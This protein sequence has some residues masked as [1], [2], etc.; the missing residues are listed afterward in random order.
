MYDLGKNFEMDYSKAKP[1]SES[2]I[3]GKNFRITILTER[4][5]RFEF[6]KHGNFEDRPTEI[7]WNR[8]FEKP[9]FEKKEDDYFL[10]IETDFFFLSYTKGKNF[11]GGRLNPG[12]N[13]KVTLKGTDKYWYYKH[14]EVRNYGACDTMFESSKGKVLYKKGLYSLDGFVTIDD[15]NSSIMLENG[16][17]E[18]RQKGNI[19][20]YLFVYGKDFASCLKDYYELTGYPALLPRYAL[21]TWWNKNVAYT[22]MTLKQLVDDFS[23]NDIPLSVL[24]LD[25]N[26]H[27]NVQ[28]NKGVLKTGFTFNNMCFKA[29]SEMIKYLHAKGIRLGLTVDPSEGI[30]PIE[31]N[32]EK[33]KSYLE[34][35][36]KGVIPFNIYDP[37]FID[38]Y[39]KLLIHPLDT[40]GVD[41]YFIDY[42]N[43]LDKLNTLKYYQA[44][45]VKRDYQR[46]PMVLSYN[47]SKASHRYP[48]LYSGKT[49]V[50]WDTLKRIPIHN[51]NAANIG[52]SWWSHDIGGYYKGIED[53][54]L[55][56]RYVELGVFSPILKFGSDKCKYYKREPWKWSIKTYT[57]VKEYLDLRRKLIPYL[58][59]E[60]YK[61]HKDG[62][63]L[64]QPLYYKYPEMYDDLLYRNE[65]YFGSEF[66]ISPITNK[67]DYI[68]NRTIH[69][70][71]V[72]DGVWYNFMTGKKFMGG[73][74]HVSFFKEQDYPVFVKAGGIIPLGY[75]DNINDTNPPKNMEIHVFP[76][77]SNM[78]TLNE[79]DGVSTLYEKGYFLRTTIDYNYLPNNYTII[80]RAVEGKSG[81]VPETRNYKII[82]RNTKQAKEIIAYFDKEQIQVSS[83]VDGPNFIVEAKNIKTI[84]QLTI[85]CKG[86]DIEID[87]LR[88]INDDIEGIISDLPIET[89]LKQL[90]DEAIFNDNEVRKKRIAVRRLRSKGLESKFVKLFL[91]LLDYMGQVQ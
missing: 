86:K 66:F 59:S 15:S 8:N 57:I 61:Y 60:A 75:N 72:P 17:T 28:T 5:I 3:V 62:T 56:A 34:A 41:F 11:Y 87:A 18:T 13:L 21:G 54:E 73:K 68:M 35:D 9:K 45:D 37:K 74:K 10:E 4:L 70:F 65:Y 89:D 51:L 82:F 44:Y 7:I 27:N 80:I 12:S 36:S 78:Y 48:V 20:I 16:Q 26:W 81:I 43:D 55:Y 24:L 22:D 42:K 88:I 32:Y 46:R 53:N 50:S 39:L 83:Y 33:I 6:N 64:I 79:D 14:P 47:T 23:D 71:F 58:Y 52:V 1:N 84:G 29:P 30:Y 91:K 25:Y 76:G 69:K 40:I 63:P 85:N 49:V 77:R 38:A 67:K 31:Q 19:D 90:I 2:I